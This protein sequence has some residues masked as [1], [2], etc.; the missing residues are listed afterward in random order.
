MSI[1]K[2]LKNNFSNLN[3]GIALIFGRCNNI[4]VRDENKKIICCFYNSEDGE[5]LIKKYLKENN[6]DKNKC[7]FEE[8]TDLSK[9]DT[10]NLI[11]NFRLTYLDQ[12]LVLYKDIIEASKNKE[13]HK[14]DH[15]HKHKDKYSIEIYF[16]S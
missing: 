9:E 14:I 7:T 10:K 12:K 4:I 3:D 8:I 5:I 6:I 15:V 16:T 11:D 2:N 13:L 1:L